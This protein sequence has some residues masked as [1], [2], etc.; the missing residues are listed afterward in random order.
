MLASHDDDTRADE[1]LLT[2]T[3]SGGMFASGYLRERPL[4]RY[5]GESER[6][7]YLLSN[8]RKGVRRESDGEA[9]AFTPGDDY[10]AI[11]AITDT[12]VLF[13]VGG[14]GEDGDETFAV[15]YTEVED[16]K[17]GRGV[18]TKRLDVWTTAG[19]R[20]RFYVRSSVDVGPAADY[21]ERAAVVWSRVEGQLQHARER[22]VDADEATADGDLD[23]A[24][25]GVAEAQSHL[26]EAQRKATELTTDRTDAIWERIGEFD[27]RLD[28]A[29][30]DLYRT[31]AESRERT[32]D[33]QW[34][35]EQYNKAHDAFLAARNQ[36]ERALEVARRYEFGNAEE[37]RECIDEVTQDLDA[38]SKSPLQ[39]AERTHERADECDD[40]AQT[41]TLLEDALE[42][43]Q[44]A[45]VLDWGSEASRFAGDSDELQ[46][47]ITQVVDEIA[48]ARRTLA[49]HARHRGRD[50][51]DA[52]RYER[53][54]V[55]FENAADHLMAAVRIARELKPDLVDGLE[56]D[57]ADVEAAIEEAQRGVEE[58]GFQ[59]VGDESEDDD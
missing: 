54:R 16:V 59:F 9:T 21:L 55:A 30:I 8:T 11:A 1:K 52:G 39:R 19:V 7:A 12:R 36:Y 29:R 44:T 35:N 3:G 15:P 33:R 50:H 10:R 42:R 48:I 24:G 22:L 58:S 20:W 4:I 56:T 2:G 17:T 25:T 47:T 40:P 37:I 53:A 41:A 6:V 49:E 31:R 13:V 28:A 27:R 26:E 43:Y 32:A 51:L 14:A 5:L 34:R 18:L 46:E 23:A 38:L 45:L 57:V